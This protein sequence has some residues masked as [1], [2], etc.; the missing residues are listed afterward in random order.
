MSLKFLQNGIWKAGKKG[1]IIG[2]VELKKEGTILNIN[3]IY[4]IFIYSK[5]FLNRPHI[6]KKKADYITCL[7]PY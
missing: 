3:K 7:L 1:N 5:T 4:L 6:I 2:T